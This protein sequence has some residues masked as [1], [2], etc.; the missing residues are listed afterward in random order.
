V[1]LRGSCTG[2]M[3]HQVRRGPAPNRPGMMRRLPTAHMIL[4]PFGVA[5]LMGQ[6]AEGQVQT[7]EIRTVN[8]MSL[9]VVSGHPTPPIVFFHNTDIPGEPSDRY[10]REQVALA[11]DAGVHIYS[12]PLRNPRLPDGLTPNYAY[13]D[14]LMDRF[15]E[16]DPEA[17]FILRVYPGPNWSWREVREKTIPE[18]EYVRFAGGESPGLSIASEW[19]ARAS[20]DDLAQLVQHYE[21][22][23]YARRI[24][25]WQPGGPYH[26]MFLADYR[27]SGP[28]YSEANHRAFR[29]WLRDRYGTDG[30][31]QE[32]WSRDGVTLETAPIP[33]P[34][35]GRF[36]MRMGAGGTPIQVFYNL[37]AE[38][39]WVDF[40]E[41]MSDITADRILEWA[42]I[43]KEQTNGRRL[44]AFF[45]GY[46]FEL[47]GS[48]AGHYRLR[49][50]LECPD[51]DILASPY[52]YADRLVGGAGNFMGPVDSVALHGKLWFNE[53]D[54]RTSLIDT[55]SL[56]EHFALFDK[57]CADLHETTSVLERNFAAILTHR[58]GTWW[59]DLVS[60][61]AFNDPSLWAMLRERVAL[62]DALYRELT[63]Y[64]PDVAVLIDEDSKL[65]V[66]DDWDTNWWTMVRLRDA[67]AKAAAS[68][69]Y[70]LLS[71]F[72]DG[73]VPECKAYL[74]ANAFRLTADQIRAIEARLTR[75]GATAIWIYAPAYLGPEGA[76]PERMRR[77]TGLRFQVEAGKLGS[78]GEGLLAEERW[79]APLPVDPRLSVVDADATPL[80]RYAEGGAVSSAMATHEGCRSIFLG[81]MGPSRTVLTKLFEAAGA[82]IWT[83]GGEVV[84]TD[85]RTLAIHTGTPGVVEVALPGG[86]RARPI[87]ADVLSED[88][89]TIRLHLPAG[90][91][92]W[93]ALT[94]GEPR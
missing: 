47:P 57:R 42:R 7:V 24:L 69:G 29:T 65:Y 48:L 50:V 19:F 89:H 26:E 85:G 81:D 31:L 92:A 94:S 67:C 87:D 90:G 36:P 8:G 62:Y 63:P 53:D 60:R 17:L 93:L 91:T 3:Q 32:A 43:V 73:L 34:D 6:A 66:K 39:D 79:G 16:V 35:A 9:L 78:I 13:S 58:A 23:T 11:R 5:V 2:L 86:M 28:D 70:Y 76:A 49:R 51:V 27:Q 14:S 75:E 38:Q 40:S 68:V 77:L 44:S 84:H 54:T 20:G 18:D 4:L 74:F 41:Y 22:S 88:A 82:H 59:M 37:P 52:S 83:R 71:D 46:T 56:P 15:I 45:Y 64:R 10:L 33:E 55:E 30:A 72:V 12:L 80:G 1:Q 21:S 25:A 61:G